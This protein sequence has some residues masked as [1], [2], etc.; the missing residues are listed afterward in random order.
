MMLHDIFGNLRQLT[1][2]CYHDENVAFPSNFLLQRF[3]NLKW[4]RV[5]CSSFKEILAED[6]FGGLNDMEKP[7]K[8]F[9]NLKTLWLVKLCNLR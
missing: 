9:E 3:P 7:F 5:E 2:S 1:L 8:A 4:L 6:A